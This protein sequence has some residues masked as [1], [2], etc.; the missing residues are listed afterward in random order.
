MSKCRLRDLGITIGKLPTGK[1]NA[2]TDVPEVLVGHQTLIYDQP[3][4]SRT[5]V[6]VIQ[7]RAD[8]SRDDH[9]FA[10]YHSF[11]GNGEMTGLLWLEESGMLGSPI[12][13]TNTNQ[14]GIVR[15]ALIEYDVAEHGG[16]GFRLPVVAETWDGW[17]NDID[18]FHLQKSHVF[19]AIY[20]AD[21]GPVAEGNVGGGTGMICHDFKG[22]I[23]TA[24]RLVDFKGKQYTVGVLVQ[25]NHGDRLDLQVD[26]VPVG[27]ELGPEQVPVPQYYQSGGSI[28][29]IIGTDAPFLPAQCKRLAQRATVGLSRVGGVGHNGSGDIFLAFSNGNTLAA[30][31]DDL[32]PL[33]MIPNSEMDPF[34]YAVIEATQESI[35]NAMIAAETMI[36]FMGRT[37]H[38]LPHDDLV[39]IMGHYQRLG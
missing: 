23:G 18:A 28:L 1:N 24:S 29:I 7:P 10:G 3:R 19:E 22:G 38:A 11:N 35:L 17:L 15:E 8:R 30:N 5:G 16:K 12:A 2:I 36:G 31:A 39:R 9:T 37:V 27:R 25:A 32:V 21:G 4:I 13:L 6:T 33:F 20:A 14:V 34:F 26:G